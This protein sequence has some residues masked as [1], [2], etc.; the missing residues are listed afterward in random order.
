M[1]SF[2]ALRLGAQVFCCAAVL[3]FFLPYGG[4]LRFLWLL[5]LLITAAAAVGFR[6]SRRLPRLALALL[7]ALSFLLPVSDLVCL[8]AGGLL[9]LYA[10]IVLTRGAVYPDLPRCRREAAWILAIC[11]LRIILALCLPEFGVGVLGLPLCA[12]LLALLSLRMLR[13]EGALGPAWQAG[14]VGM[15]AAVLAAGALAGLT[16]WVSR[17][18]L[19]SVLRF[20]LSCAAFLLTLPFTLVLW[21]WGS[22]FV[23]PDFPDPTQFEELPKIF[24]GNGENTHPSSQGT[25]DAALPEVS[26]RI[27]WLTILTACGTLLLILAAV[28]LIRSGGVR[29][30]RKKRLLRADGDVLPEPRAKRK[31]R[32]APPPDNRGRLRLIYSRYLDYLRLRGVR[33]GPTKTTEEITA[34]SSEL[35]VQ[36][37]ERL[38]SL[39]RKARYSTEPIT[40]EE[41]NDAQAIFDSLISNENRA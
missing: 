4:E 10:A 26:V 21:L 8:T 37:D 40:D 18:V 22:I 25:I 23:I 6:F 7:P 2:P 41:V 39:Y 19:L 5:V 36:G 9:C 16:L 3:S 14:S 24:F 33:V 13:T 1:R 38:R 29:R 17:A 34:V 20:I 35:F 11:G 28:W 12:V 32:R 15:L 31:K 27:P 30:L